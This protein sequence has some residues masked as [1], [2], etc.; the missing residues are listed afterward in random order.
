MKNKISRVS[1]IIITTLLYFADVNAQQGFGTS[2]PNANSIIDLTSTKKGLLLPRLSLTSTTS[3]LPLTTHTAGM[4]VY[5][6]FTSALATDNVTP[7]YYF[8][9][10]LKW[11]RFT[12]NADAT[13]DAFL[14][15][16]SNTR[17]ELNTKSDGVTARTIGNFFAVQDDGRVGIGTNSP[18]STL[19]ILSNVTSSTRITN[20]GNP[21]DIY[22]RRAQ[23]TVGGTAA[24]NNISGDGTILGRIIA[25]GFYSAYRDAASITLETD[26]PTS[27]TDLA[28]RILFSTTP[29]AATVPVERLRISREGYIGIGTGAATT[30]TALLNIA[31]GTTSVAPIRLTSGTNLSTVQSG[32]LEYDGTNFFATNSTPTRF[33][34]AKTLTNAAVLDFPNTIAQTSSDLTLTITGAADGD[35]VSLGAQAGAINPNSNFTAWVSA[36]NT[37]TVRFNNYSS[38][39]IDPASG[40]F[41]ISI[42]KY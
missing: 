31:A 24:A 18:T 23:G 19:E 5:N 35:A 12:E 6:T 9:D 28:G 25:S 22:L 39:A 8:N 16:N 13:N 4:I 20:Y 36:A 37:V 42:L 2:S 38:G 21:N 30:A 10:G 17:V 1:L 29:L 27:A 40:T 26:G 11:N 15:N 41:R 7:G 14:N 3:F 32:A 33:T 34:L